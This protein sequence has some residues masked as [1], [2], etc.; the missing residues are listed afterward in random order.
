MS[1]TLD[2]RLEGVYLTSTAAC[3]SSFNCGALPTSSCHCSLRRASVSV[4]VLIAEATVPTTASLEE[5]VAKAM[6]LAPASVPVK[7]TPH[8]IHAA[9]HRST[10][11]DLRDQFLRE[12]FELFG[13]AAEKMV[14]PLA[15]CHV[16]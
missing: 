7:A 4:I 14:P 5:L 10:T 12:S 15:R 11:Q 16:G 9:V 2:V 13:Q 1:C 8:G 3:E 6:L